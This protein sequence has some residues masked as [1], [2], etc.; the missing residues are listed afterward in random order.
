MGGVSKVEFHK[1]IVMVS[2]Q[3]TFLY[4]CVCREGSCTLLCIKTW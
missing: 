3:I 2:Y 4:A 1:Q